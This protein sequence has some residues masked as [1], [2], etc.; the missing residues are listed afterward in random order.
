MSEITCNFF[1][2]FLINA[3]YPVV[4][5]ILDLHMGQNNKLVD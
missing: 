3:V 4:T 5:N 2:V 1:N